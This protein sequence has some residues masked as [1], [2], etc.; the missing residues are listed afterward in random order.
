MAI[1]DFDLKPRG[2]T[3]LP[4][5]GGVCVLFFAALGS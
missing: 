2:N 3:T 1:Y 5:S 4:Y